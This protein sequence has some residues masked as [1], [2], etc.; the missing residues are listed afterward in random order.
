MVN[1]KLLIVTG[2][3]GAK[4]YSEEL[5]QEI[6]EIDAI[7]GT[8]SYQ[9]IDEIIANLEKE[10]HIVSLN[11]IEFAFNEELPRYVLLQAIWLT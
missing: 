3:L 5:K 2:C 8:G 6:P 7:V 1:L 9:Q 10:N 4:R 11:D